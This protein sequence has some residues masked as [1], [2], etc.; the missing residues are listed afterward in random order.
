MHA[1]LQRLSLEDSPGTASTK[2]GC[3]M[4]LNINI[5]IP[6][7]AVA[8]I[9]SG[10]A[11]DHEQLG[12]LVT[13]AVRSLPKTMAEPAITREDS[14]VDI[15]ILLGAEEQTIDERESL[16]QRGIQKMAAQQ[17]P[18]KM[19]LDG[20]GYIEVM[21]D[22]HGCYLLLV[23]ANTTGSA[24]NNMIVEKTGIPVERQ[25]LAFKEGLFRSSDT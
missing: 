23:S 1:V 16:R 18:P 21:W 5:V 22:F 8:A 2:A 11:V 9:M 6:L 7:P 3:N 12:Y 10:Q 13:N 4:S 15:S 14:A 17:Q 25:R 19:H 20:K 24:L